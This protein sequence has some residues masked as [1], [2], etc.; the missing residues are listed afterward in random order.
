MLA[1][2]ELVG[3]SFNAVWGCTDSRFFGPGS[4]NIRVLS[5]TGSEGL[6][7]TK[8]ARIMFSLLQERYGG[9]STFQLFV[10]PSPLSAT[11]THA[12]LPVE[13]PVG[14]PDVRAIVSSC[15]S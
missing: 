12:Q 9:G 15:L 6:V 13:R 7:T 8:F 5:T 1:S 3:T 4:W 10:L 11:Q 2:L 14:S